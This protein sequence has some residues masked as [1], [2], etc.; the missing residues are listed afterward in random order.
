MHVFDRSLDQFPAAA[1]NAA[2]VLLVELEVL[3]ELAAARELA[4][5]LRGVSH[6]GFPAAG[7]KVTLLGRTEERGERCG[8]GLARVARPVG[9]DNA[10][11]EEADGGAVEAARDQT[12]RVEVGVRGQLW[13]EGGC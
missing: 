10:A 3:D 6:S 2:E 1:D 11:V 4:V 7:S 12:E 13:G 9:D 8:E 5:G